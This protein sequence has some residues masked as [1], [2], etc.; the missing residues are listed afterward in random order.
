MWTVSRGEK[1]Q[2]I[3]KKNNLE[4]YMTFTPHGD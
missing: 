4:N 3:T 1:W 2:I